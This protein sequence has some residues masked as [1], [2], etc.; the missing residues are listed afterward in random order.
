[1]EVCTALN[2]PAEFLIRRGFLREISKEEALDLLGRTK[3]EGL[4]YVGDNVKRRPTFICH[5]CGCC[6][7]LLGAYMNFQMTHAVATSAYIA[8]VD[9]DKCV[10]CGRCAKSCQ[11]NL[12]SIVS[13][14]EEKHAVVD[15]DLC[16]GCGVCASVCAQSAITMEHR[17]E[18]IITPET[19]ME[20][21]VTMALEQGK[22]GNFIYDDFTSLPYGVLRSMVNAITKLPSVKKYLASADV[23]SRF[24]KR[25][26][27]R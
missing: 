1:M 18:R 14:H 12:I 8:R 10:G 19:A 5:C 26:A 15:E 3:E 7:A 16:L 21:W 17:G 13:D 2:G 24:L 6:C 9:R 25:L 4:V 20:K 11:V 27:H 22:L 23:K